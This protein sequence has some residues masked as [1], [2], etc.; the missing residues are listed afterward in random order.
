MCIF[1]FFSNNIGS[2][3]PRSDPTIQDPTYLPQSHLPPTILRR[4][5]ILATLCVC[6][7]V[8]MYVL[9]NKHTYTRE[10]ER[11]YNAKAHYNSTQKSW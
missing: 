7:C 8:C 5:P 11:D 4:I 1:V 10:R 3:D 9:R 2:Y 6:V